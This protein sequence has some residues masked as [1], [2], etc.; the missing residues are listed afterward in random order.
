MALATL[1]E[2]P[3]CISLEHDPVICNWRVKSLG[4]CYCTR[5][6]PAFKKFEDIS[7]KSIIP[8]QLSR[9][10]SDTLEADFC[11]DALEEALSMG[12][13]RIFNTDLL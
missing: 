5:T 4:L 3:N 7:V 11:V 13:P 12:V 1:E 6:G 9:S 10:Q 2:P 8:T